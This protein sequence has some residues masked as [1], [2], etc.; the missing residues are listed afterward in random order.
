MKIPD[1]EGKIVNS[2]EERGIEGKF[3]EGRGYELS[4]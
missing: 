1:R 2:P 4:D 3:R